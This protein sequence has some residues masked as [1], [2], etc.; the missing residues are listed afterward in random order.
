MG[1]GRWN[2]RNIRNK[3]IESGTKRGF[4]IYPAACLIPVSH[5]VGRSRRNGEEM[6]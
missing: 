3:G 6:G 4:W 1:K 5:K 2:I